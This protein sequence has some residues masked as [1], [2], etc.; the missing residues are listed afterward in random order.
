MGGLATEVGDAT[1]TILLEDAH[2]DPVCIRATE[3]RLALPSEASF[4]FERTVDLEKKCPLIPGRLKRLK[5]KGLSFNFL[6]RLLR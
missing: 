6:P 2:F 3:R 5:G 4:R 1:T